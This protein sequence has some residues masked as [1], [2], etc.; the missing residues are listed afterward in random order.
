MTRAIGSLV[1]LSVWLTRLGVAGAETGPST[2]RPGVD[3]GIRL[4]YAIPIGNISGAPGDGMNDNFWGAIP[5]VLEAAYRINDA[6]SVGGLFQDALLQLKD[7]ATTG[8]GNGLSCSGSVLRL[9]VQGTYHISSL[10]H[11]TFIPWVGVGTGYEWLRLHLSQGGTSVSSA[12]RGVEFLT[13]HVGADFRQSPELSLG[14]F[15]SLSIGQYETETFET[16]SNSTSVTIANTALHG[17]IQLGVRGLFN[18]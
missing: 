1:L 7:N 9:G 13:I 18:L 5:F 2:D 11:S 17:W 4:G 16:N 10:G 8:C 15:V 6:I 3:L 14:P 12:A